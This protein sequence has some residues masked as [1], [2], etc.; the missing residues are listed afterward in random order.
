MF[1]IFFTNN[2]ILKFYWYYS[3]WW[4]DMLMHF[5]GGFW[6]GLFFV[7]V[8][9]NKN[10]FSKQLLAVIFCVLLFGI[11]WEFFEFFMNVIAHDSFDIL[12]TL[13]DIFFDLAGGFSAIFYCYKKIMPTSSS[14]V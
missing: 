14:A 12:D 4:L 8:F 7:Y 6:V 5:L 3:I 1:F 11:L 9:Y 10:T 2:V 13:S